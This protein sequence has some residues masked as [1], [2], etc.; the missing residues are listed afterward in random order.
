MTLLRAGKGERA[1]FALI[2]T[3][4]RGREDLHLPPHS[5]Q[6]QLI[7]STSLS[8]FLE[9]SPNADQAQCVVQITNDIPTQVV[10]SYI[11]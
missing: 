4:Y 2:T 5:S 6:P 11:N 9:A 10:V 3:C 7:P 1:R 8:A